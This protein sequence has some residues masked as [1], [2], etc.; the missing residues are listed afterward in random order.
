MARSGPVVLGVVGDTFTAPARVLAV[1]WEGATTSG[2]TA[3]VRARDGNLLWAGRTNTT[4]TYLGVNLGEKG[5][6]V[7]L[8]FTLTQLSA[9]RV[10][11]YLKED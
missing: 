9:G 5:I 10:L 1:I 8:G 11:V 7:P 2:D 3:E 4:H 6:G